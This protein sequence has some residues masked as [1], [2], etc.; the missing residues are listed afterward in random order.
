MIQ[1]AEESMV[2][3]A[4]HWFDGRRLVLATKHGKETLIS[5]LFISAFGVDPFVCPDLDTDRFGTFTGE[6]PRTHDPLTTARMKCLAAMDQSGCDLGLASEGSFGPH[7][8]FVF[9]PADE[10]LIILI[11]RKNGFEITAIETSTST[12]FRSAEVNTFEQVEEFARIAGFPQHALILRSPR[13]NG[14]VMKGISDPDIL[15]QTYLNLCSS[16]GQILIETDMRACHNPS[17]MQVIGKTAQK[18]CGRINSL[19]PGC[20]APGFVVTSIDPGLP[21]KNCNTPTR[22]P[23]ETISS[24]P[25]CSYSIRILYPEGKAQEEPMYCDRCNP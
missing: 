19:C 18:L 12:N 15:H 10:E 1:A 13:A 6:M 7:P 4:R 24:C 25:K 2:N 17:R 22:S 20:N 3:D 5:P 11:D 23:I 21:C 9:I 14:R 16:S 8:S